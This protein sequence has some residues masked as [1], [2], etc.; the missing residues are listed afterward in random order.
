[1]TP[2]KEYRALIEYYQMNDGNLSY[3]DAWLKAHCTIT[4]YHFALMD[5]ERSLEEAGAK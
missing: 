5:Y 3:S 1:M 4:D 2:H